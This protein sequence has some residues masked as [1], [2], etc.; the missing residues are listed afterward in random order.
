MGHHPLVVSNHFLVKVM[1]RC[2]KD[3]NSGNQIFFYD[4]TNQIKI[5]RKQLMVDKKEIRKH[6]MLGEICAAGAQHFL[7]E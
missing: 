5:R 1:L 2:G 6:P 7:T 4:E 3:T